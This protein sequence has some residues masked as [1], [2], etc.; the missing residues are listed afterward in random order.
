MILDVLRRDMDAFFGFPHFFDET[1][2]HLTIETWICAGV[3]LQ[4]VNIE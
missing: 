3:S 2:K 4:P 1:F